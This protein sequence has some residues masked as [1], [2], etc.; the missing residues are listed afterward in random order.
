[1]T[2][3]KIYDEKTEIRFFSK[4]QKTDSCWLWNAAKDKKGYGLFS[5]GPSRNSDGKRRNSMVAAHR[6]SYELHF[7]N[8]AQHDSHHG[9]CVLHKCDNPSCVNP[10]HLFIGTNLENVQDMD[11]KGRRV[12]VTTRGS[13]HPNSILSESQIVEIVRRH[14]IDKVSQ[15]QLSK[16]YGVCHATINHIFTGRLWGH[17]GL[18]DKKEN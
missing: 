15:L 7:G 17:L 11:S 2:K 9:L 5:V 14:R 16:E 8:I 3:L 10:K 6:F 12:V 1:M 4:V 18:I 13:K